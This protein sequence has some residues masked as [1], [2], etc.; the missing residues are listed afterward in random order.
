VGVDDQPVVPAQVPRHVHLNHPA[1]R[2]LLEEF[3]RVKAMVLRVHK[4]VVHVEHQPRAAL[5]EHL[6]DEV[7]LAHLG[8]AQ[9]RIERH[10]LERQRHPQPV[11]RLLEARH[12][13]RHRLPGEGHRQQLVQHHARRAAPAQVLAMNPGPHPPQKAP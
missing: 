12:R 5:V 2:H 10:V 13:V 1:Q 9:V 6:V 11:L 4:N 3:H 8:L 7:G